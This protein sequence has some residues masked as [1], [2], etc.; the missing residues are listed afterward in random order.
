MPVAE[1][2]RIEIAYELAGEVR[3]DRLGATGCH[4][5]RSSGRA[6]PGA[7]GEL[8]DGR[9]RGASLDRAAPA[10][11]AAADTSDLSAA[12]G[13]STWHDLHMQPAVWGTHCGHLF[14]G[15]AGR[16][17][18]QEAPQRVVE[19]LDG[20][21]VAHVAGARNRNELGVRDRLVQGRGDAR[22]GAGVVLSIDEQRG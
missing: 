3:A 7:R 15:S 6:L 8:T 18:S 17:R 10:T 21:D 22:G 4:V 20:V 19:R 9:Y 11:S 13:G 14:E 1:L 2:D 16:M 12:V 5:D